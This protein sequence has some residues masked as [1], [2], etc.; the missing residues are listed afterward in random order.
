MDLEEPW[1]RSYQEDAASLAVHEE[2][3]ALEGCYGVHAG[4]FLV[5]MQAITRKTS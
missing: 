3:N 4:M 2:G 1:N 5:S